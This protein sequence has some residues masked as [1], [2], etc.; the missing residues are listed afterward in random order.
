MLDLIL[1]KLSQESTWRG[2]IAISMACG[3]SVAPEA[4]AAIVAAGMGVIGLINVIKNPPK[5]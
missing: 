5:K 4:A 2:L 3:L 1:T